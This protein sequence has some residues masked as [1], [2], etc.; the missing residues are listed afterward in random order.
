MVRKLAS[1]FLIG[2]LFLSSLGLPVF[3]HICMGMGK[4]WASI[5]IPPSDCCSKQ[6]K[7]I[8]MFPDPAQIQKV[9]HV[10]KTPCCENEI[11]LVSLESSYTVQIQLVISFFCIS[12]FPPSLQQFTQNF[13]QISDTHPLG[14]TVDIPHRYGRSLLI[15]EQL[16][17]C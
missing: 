3:T 5:L 6:A 2:V 9:C 13:Q 4:T 16:L 12:P 7:N 17:L 14:Y 8:G 10:S 11:A 15:F 1:F